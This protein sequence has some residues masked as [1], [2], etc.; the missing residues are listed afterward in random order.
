MGHTRAIPKP[1]VRDNGQGIPGTGPLCW[2]VGGDDDDGDEDFAGKLCVAQVGA[3]TTPVLGVSTPD[4]EG[5]GAP[6]R[7]Q[8]IPGSWAPTWPAN[9]CN[10]DCCSSRFARTSS[11]PSSRRPDRCRRKCVQVLHSDS[12]KT[13][14]PPKVTLGTSPRIKCFQNFPVRLAKKCH[15]LCEKKT[16]SKKRQSKAPAKDTQNGGQLSICPGVRAPVC[17]CVCASPTYRRKKVAPRA[18][19]LPEGKCTLYGKSFLFLDFPLSL[20]FSLRYF[21]FVFSHFFYF[22]CCARKGVILQD[23]CNHL[24]SSFLS[25]L[26]CITECRLV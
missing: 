22:P 16:K 6:G 25:F 3:A 14:V 1:A 8:G 7:T 5:G 20:P 4:R 13:I 19:S 24:P 17:L 12:S 10:F 9:Q 26:F 2:Q 23:L 11:S 18:L 15:D 21:C